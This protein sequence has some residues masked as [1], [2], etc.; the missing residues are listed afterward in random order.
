VWKIC[1]GKIEIVCFVIKAGRNLTMVVKVEVNM[2]RNETD[3]TVAIF[4]Y[5]KFFLCYINGIQ[6]ANFRLL[7]DRTS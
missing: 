6:F 5:L 7:I 2:S 4:L 1:N 3:K